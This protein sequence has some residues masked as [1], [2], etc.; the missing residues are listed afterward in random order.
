MSS[1]SG[2]RPVCTTSCRPTCADAASSSSRRCTSTPPSVRYSGWRPHPCLDQDIIDR[3]TTIDLLAT[4]GVTN[5]M[6]LGAAMP[7]HFAEG[8]VLKDQDREGMGLGDL[9]FIAKFNLVQPGPD[10]PVGLGVVVPI[11]L[12][13]GDPTRWLGEDSV[14]ARPALTIDAA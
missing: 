6:E 11:S 5:W 10:R 9:R 14:S 2:R 7:L 3:L 8:S 12:P 1:S 13:T 4:F